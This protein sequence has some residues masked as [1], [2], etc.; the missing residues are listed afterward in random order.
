MLDLL[1]GLI[2]AGGRDIEST[3]YG[4]RRHAMTSE[5]SPERDRFELAL[6]RRAVERDLPL[7]GIC[8]G[9]EL[10]NVAHGGDLEQHLPDVLGH[11]VHSPAPDV[12]SDHPVRLA[13]GSLAAR[14]AGGTDQAVKSHHHQGLGRLAEGF[15]ATGWAEPDGIVE[16]IERPDRRFVVG[17]LFHPEEDSDSRV[18]ASF[19]AEA[20]AARAER[21]EPAPG[22]ADRVRAREPA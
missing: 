16:A 15:E 17:V 9:C 12:F 5:P 20:R 8:R 22:T 21:A 4:A 6:V 11:D 7:L 3:S 2:L 14:V 13:P 18:L 10:L 1:D 19:V